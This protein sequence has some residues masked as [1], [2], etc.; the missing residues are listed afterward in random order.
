MSDS[1]H[2][3]EYRLLLDR[4]KKA[5]R[6]AGL[7]QIDVAKRLGHH[8]SHISKIEIGERRLDVI[9]LAELARIYSISMDYVLGEIKNTT[10]YDKNTKKQINKV[11]N[12]SKSKNKNNH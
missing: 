7:T 3:L 8:Q 4:L 9:E 12:N 5:R 2:T 11:K 1:T 6:S 10:A